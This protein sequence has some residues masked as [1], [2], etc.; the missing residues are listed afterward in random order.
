MSGRNLNWRRAQRKGSR[1]RERPEKSPAS[2]VAETRVKAILLDT[3]E[4]RA[5]AARKHKAF[6]IAKKIAKTIRKRLTGKDVPPEEHAARI[7]RIVHK[8]HMAHVRK[9]ETL[10]DFG[11]GYVKVDTV[12][13]PDNDDDGQEN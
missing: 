12:A 11:T 8:R 6:G 9:R 2:A 10:P 5:A 1:F 4:S 13:N 7:E 3:P